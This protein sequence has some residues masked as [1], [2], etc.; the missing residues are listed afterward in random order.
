M[1][2]G[3]GGV[4][5]DDLHSRQIEEIGKFLA[6]L[7]FTFAKAE[8]RRFRQEI[9]GSLVDALMRFTGNPAK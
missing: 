9:D 6:V 3:D 2:I 5:V 8:A 7:F 4:D 1:A